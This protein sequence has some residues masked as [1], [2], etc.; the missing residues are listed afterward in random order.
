VLAPARADDEDLHDRT[1]REAVT[2]S[3]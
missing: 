2:G 3:R 1:P